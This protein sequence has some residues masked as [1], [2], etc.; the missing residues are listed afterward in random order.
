MATV[1]TIT[2]CLSFRDKAEEAAKFY[3]SVFK[4]SRIKQVARYGEAGR[5]HHKQPPGSVM[6]VT[7]EIDGQPFAALNG[8]P[9]D[10]FNFQVSLMASCD[11]QAE[12][13]RLWSALTAGGGKPIRC[14][15]LTDRF[16]VAWQI[17]PSNLS[18]LMDPKDQAACDRTM[19]AVMGMVKLDIAA[20][21]RAHDGT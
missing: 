8:G 14:G 20:M 21:Q 15:W 10:P 13:D 3:V 5:E 16:G 7:F 2:P 4:N 19:L 9:S 12:I 11:T 1:N 18:H 6:F 17:V